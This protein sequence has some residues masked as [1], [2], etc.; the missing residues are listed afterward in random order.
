MASRISS[1][2]R[3]SD[4]SRTS[5]AI[6][7]ERCSSQSLLALP[8]LKDDVLFAQVADREVVNRG[9]DLFEPGGKQPPRG[10]GQCGRLRQ[11]AGQI[12]KTQRTRSFRVK[13]DTQGDGGEIEES[14]LRTRRAGE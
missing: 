12:E 6:Q 13:P 2:L 7:S 9:P 14:Q 4:S 11:P 5:P 3:G 1:R 10:L 8:E